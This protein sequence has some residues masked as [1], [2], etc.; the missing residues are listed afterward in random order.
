VFAVSRVA[1]EIRIP[2]C[3][4]RGVHD[5]RCATTRR[6]C[7]STWDS[8]KQ[9]RKMASIEKIL[10]SGGRGLSKR[11]RGEPSRTVFFCP[12]SKRAYVS[13]GIAITSSLIMVRC[14]SIFEDDPHLR[15]IRATSRLC[16]QP[17]LPEAPGCRNFSHHFIHRAGFYG[18]RAEPVSSEWTRKSRHIF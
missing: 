16:R 18:A 4:F 7:P 5:T 13:I 2:A 11:N 12:V 17:Q 10:R 3:L 14:R 15:M 9:S 8:G 1:L 6:F